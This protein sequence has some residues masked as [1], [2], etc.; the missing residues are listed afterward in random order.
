M[1]TIDSY[2]WAQEALGENGE[3]PGHPIVLACMVMDRYPDILAAMRREPGRDF[4]NALRDSFIPGAGCAVHAA[5][6]SLRQGREHGPAAAYAHAERYWQGWEE[7]RT[8]NA[9][10]AARGREQCE[11]IKARFEAQLKTWGTS[12][13]PGSPYRIQ[14]APGLAALP[15]VA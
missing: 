11:R 15:V 6:E 9:S 5:L 7:Q 13:D 14:M 10:S 2:R 1:P 4:G 12:D 8:D 3:Y